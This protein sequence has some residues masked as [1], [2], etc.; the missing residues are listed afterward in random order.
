MKIGIIGGS[1]LSDTEIS[2]EKIS[3]QTPY[4]EPS[5]P[6]EVEDIGFTKTLFLKRHGLNH[7]IPPHKVNYRANIYGF[8]Q[9]GI[10]RIIGIFAVGSL[11][12]NI[13]PGSI[14]LPDQ[15]IDFIQG[16]R[17]NTFYEEGKVVHIDFTEPFCHEMRE[18]FIKTAENLDIPIIS[19][20][21]YICVNGPRLE[22]AAEIK[23]YKSIGADIVGM[24]LMPEAS[25]AREVEICYTAV[26]VVANYAAGIS[27]KPL[28]VKEV[29]ESMKASLDVIKKIVKETIKN[30]PQERACA[31]KDALKNASF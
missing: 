26:A 13:P 28:T 15:I 6:Y 18:C 5:C 3:I 10:E 25:L 17:K 12:E 14:V 16:M 31:C 27:K 11:N 8:K 23:F 30:L 2:N 7:S 20:G 1:G 22:T 29:V 24:T 21:T 4:G 19:N 9:L